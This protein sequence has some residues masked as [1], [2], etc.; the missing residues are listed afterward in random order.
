MA[1]GCLTSYGAT[2][3]TQRI[4]NCLHP[5]AV[6]TSRLAEFWHLLCAFFSS[7]RVTMKR[8]KAQNVNKL[9]HVSATACSAPEGVGSRSAGQ[10]AAGNA[11]APGASQVLPHHSAA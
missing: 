8:K 7:P 5:I 2:S 10:P 11:A 6:S 3:R 4:Q 1:L 9:V